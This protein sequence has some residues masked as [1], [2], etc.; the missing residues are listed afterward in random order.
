MHRR[1]RRVDEMLEPM[2]PISETE[3]AILRRLL[4]LDFEGADALRVQAAH[5]V[6]VESNCK[7]GCPSITPH[8]DREKAPPADCTSPIPVELAEMNRPDGGIP[9]TVLCFLDADGYLANLEC[10]YYDDSLPEWPEP[11]Y[12]A[13]MLRDGDGY[14]SQITLPSGAL[15]HPKEPGDYWVSFEEQSDGGF[16]A[17]TWGGYRECYGPRGDL[18]TRT[19]TK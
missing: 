14:L 18:R 8:V 19:F 10:V 15:I 5:I 7:C 3:R 17:S 13:L 6:G 11:A 2:R 4:S 1:W 16:C 9:R 12:C